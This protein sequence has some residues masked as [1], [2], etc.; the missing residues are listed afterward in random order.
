MALAA[1]FTWFIETQW[2]AFKTRT[3]TTTDDEWDILS[4][5][6]QL[7]NRL[8]LVSRSVKALVC[9]EKFRKVSVFIAS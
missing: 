2:G 5:D 7:L 6:V 8:C 3:T 4:F 9:D 1:Q